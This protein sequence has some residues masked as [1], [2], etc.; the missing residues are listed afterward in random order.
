M[1][2]INMYENKKQRVFAITLQWSNSPWLICALALSLFGCPD[3]VEPTTSEKDMALEEDMDPF[4]FDSDPVEEDMELV[5]MEPVEADMVSVDED[6]SCNACQED[7]DCG[8][9]YLCVAFDEDELDKRCFRPCAEGE[10][11]TEQCGD[12]FSCLELS[13]DLQ[14]CVADE[15]S[16]E[17]CYDPDGDGYGAG[18]TCANGDIDCNNNDRRINPDRDDD[19][20]GVDNDCDEAIDED[21]EVIDCGVGSCQAQS[22]CVDGVEQSCVPPE[23]QET[24][25]TCDGADDDCD[26]SLDEDF[27]PSICGLGVCEARTTCFEGAETSCEEG[28]PTADDDLTCDG[29]DEDCDGSVDESY[30]GSC[31]DGACIRS[32]ACSE[33]IISCE[34]REPDPLETDSLCDNFDADCDGSVDE[35]FSTDVTCGEGAC[36]VT[37]TCLGG[38]LVCEPLAPVVSEDTTCDGIDD[39]C[40]GEIDEDC[41]VNTLRVEHNTELSTDSAVA[42]DIFYDQLYSPSA[43]PAFFQPTTIQVTLN[44]PSGMSKQLTIAG[45]SLVDAGKTIN[46][47][48]I[49]PNNA[50]QVFAYGDGAA[51]AFP[52]PASVAAGSQRPA[53]DG[54]LLTMLFN[55]NGVAAP[56]TFSWDVSFSYFSP[57]RAM[58]QFAAVLDAD[59]NPTY[60]D[61]GDPV[62][63]EVRRFLEF[64]PI[65]PV[66]P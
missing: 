63:E 57:E 24:D 54:K 46:E 62:E 20:D 52:I 28:E 44:Y 48:F 12:D 8:E 32:A 4:T 27:V 35:G 65:A 31:G 59:G 6:L 50:Y 22:A 18:G 16:C 51:S 55:I 10:D 23:V 39:D 33:G 7:S 45:S 29:L 19:C 21:F 43:D 25:A 66:N 41:H 58:S 34:P 49:Q 9:G 36:K 15:G 60:D 26:G 47:P 42:L 5:D 64:S 1:K 17:L 2:E 40:D 56:W 30:T 13:D 14:I 37:Q 11:D 38:D 53:R 61:N 3:S